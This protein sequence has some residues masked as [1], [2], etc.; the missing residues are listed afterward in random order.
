[1][2]TD[3]APWPEY[4]AAYH[5]R[6]PGITEMAFEHARDRRLGSPYDWLVTA[7]PDRPGDVLDV[8]C[9]NAPLHPRLPH[10]ATYLGV[11]LSDAELQAARALRRGPV[12]HGDARALPVPNASADTVVSSMG[13][14]LV[15]P[16]TRAI[17]EIARV[18]RPGGTAAFLL[19]ARIPLHLSDVRPLAVLGLHLHGPGSMPQHI[20]RRRLTR[21]LA[22]ARLTTT[23]VTTHRF[24]LPLH[25]P[26]DAGLAVRCLYTPGRSPAQLAAAES[27][28]ARTAR[29]GR[30]LPLPLLR[31]VARKPG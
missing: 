10:A 8:A 21:L 30:Q 16:L 20:G 19:P 28:L 18:L 17:D 14:M 29:P 15:R 22:K 5:A 4:L 3:P 12:T 31:L 27:A 13:L 9:G 25:T 23:S 7:L 2:S 11:D 1:M 24:G 26:A 6:R